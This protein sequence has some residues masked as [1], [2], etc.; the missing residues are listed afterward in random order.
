M[1]SISPAGV[2]VLISDGMVNLSVMSVHCAEVKAD[3]VNVLPSKSVENAICTPAGLNA[4][5]LP[6]G[7]PLIENESFMISALTYLSLLM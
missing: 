2:S 1:M 7:S 6:E 4:F 3:S 5:A